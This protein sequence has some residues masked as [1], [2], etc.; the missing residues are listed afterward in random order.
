METLTYL[1]KVV[2]NSNTNFCYLSTLVWYNL[3]A[4]SRVEMGGQLVQEIA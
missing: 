4:F 3:L 1:S 2:L